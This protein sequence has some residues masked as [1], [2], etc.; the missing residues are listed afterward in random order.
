MKRKK[1]KPANKEKRKKPEENIENVIDSHRFWNVVNFTVWLNSVFFIL[2][3]FLR[4][5]GRVLVVPSVICFA[6][7]FVRYFISVTRL[8]SLSFNSFIVAVLNCNVWM[9]E[10]HSTQVHI[11]NDFVSWT[12]KSTNKCDKRI[13][14]QA[15]VSAL[16]IKMRAQCRFN[17]LNRFHANE[18]KMKIYKYVDDGK[19]CWQKRR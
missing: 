11:N 14:A 2:V 7:R 13:P 9:K 3:S 1:N 19:S 16:V 17:W 10:M 18:M 4:D 5:H 8:H 6:M 15:Q 12:R